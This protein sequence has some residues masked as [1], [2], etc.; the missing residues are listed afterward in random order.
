[1]QNK[2]RRKLLEFPFRISPLF[3]VSNKSYFLQF[4]LEPDLLPSLLQC[5]FIISR[6]YKTRET[7]YII[8][9]RRAAIIF[10]LQHLFEYS[11][12]MVTPRFMRQIES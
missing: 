11:H 9:N 3:Y 1:M 6:D 10:V 5:N 8:R 2:F 7:I 12:D 4:N